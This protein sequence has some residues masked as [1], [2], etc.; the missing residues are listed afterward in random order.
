MNRRFKYKL[1][2]MCLQMNISLTARLAKIAAAAG[3]SLIVSCAPRQQIAPVPDVI[4]VGE[5]AAEEPAEEDEVDFADTKNYDIG[6][7][8]IEENG[9]YWIKEKDGWREYKQ[10]VPTS[11]FVIETNSSLIMMGGKFDNGAVYYSKGLPEDHSCYK[12]E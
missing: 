2:L 7:A 6:S 3:L 8:I 4:D 10:C 11:R 1:S 9:N 12:G 5:P